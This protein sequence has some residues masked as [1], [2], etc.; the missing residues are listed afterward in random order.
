MTDQTCHIEDTR[1]VSGCT[2][3]CFKKETK[4]G[5][6][7]QDVS[8]SAGKDTWVVLEL[9]RTGLCVLTAISRGVDIGSYFQV[10]WCHLL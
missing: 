6:C 1:I 7:D 9:C 10:P 4:P 3:L 8:P 2:V 5:N